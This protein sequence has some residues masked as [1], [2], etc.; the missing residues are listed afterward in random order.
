M[1]LD[2]YRTLIREGE[3]DGGTAPVVE[4]VVE[5]TDWRAEFSPELKEAPSIKD[6][7]NPEALAKSYVEQAA[8]LGNAIRPPG[9]EASEEDKRKFYTQIQEHAGDK[10]VPRPDPEDA[11]TMAAYAKAMGR[12]DEATGYIPPELEEFNIEMFD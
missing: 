9:P 4:P 10:L 6:F 8:Y 7:E 12:P 1:F 2:K 5:P 3:N 11:E